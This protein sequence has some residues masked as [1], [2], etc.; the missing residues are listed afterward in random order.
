MPDA[1]ARNPVVRSLVVGARLSGAWEDIANPPLPVQG[2]Q[3]QPQRLFGA[4]GTG[5]YRHAGAVLFHVRRG[6]RSDSH[7]RLA[8]G[9]SGLNL[10]IGH[11]AG[12]S[13]EDMAGPA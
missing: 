8:G 4:G 6:R 2:N 10:D 5:G 11:C 3:H 12:E 9:A 1:S 13:R 7:Y